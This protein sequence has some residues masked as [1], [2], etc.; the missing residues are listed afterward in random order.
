MNKADRYFES[1]AYRDVDDTK[2]DYEGFYNPIVIKAFGEY[3]TKHR[4]QSDGKLR[5]SDNWQKGTPIPVYMKSLLRHTIDVWLEHRGYE[6]R[7]GVIDGLCGII[8]NAQGMLYEI[9]KEMKE[10]V[11]AEETSEILGTWRRF[12]VNV[13]KDDG[14]KK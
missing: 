11:S 8:F 5:D 9:L 13:L 3:M 10:P 4:V 6:S 7:E 12:D 1:G 2:P 14:E